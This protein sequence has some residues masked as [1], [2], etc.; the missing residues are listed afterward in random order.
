MQRSRHQFRVFS[1]IVVVLAMHLCFSHRAARAQS[2]SP[3]QP[4]ITQ[5]SGGSGASVDPFSGGFSFGL[6]VVSVPGPEGSGTSMTLSYHSGASPEAG[7]S[8]VG[9]GW[10][11]NAGAIVRNTRGIPDDW[12]GTITYHNRRPDFVTLMVKARLGLETSSD[13]KDSVKVGFSLG[14]SLNLSYNRNTGYFKSTTLDAQVMGMASLS[15]DLSDTGITFHPHLSPAA[16][17]KLLS[18]GGGAGLVEEIGGQLLAGQMNQWSGRIFNALPKQSI[19]AKFCGESSSYQLALLVALP[20]LPFGLGPEVGLD[21]SVVRIKTD[22]VE[23]VKAY[24]YLY[25]SKATAPDQQDYYREQENVPYTRGGKTLPIPLTGADQF[26]ISGGG[27]G[28][29]RFYLSGIGQY[30][31]KAVQ[32]E[33][34]ALDVGGNLMV[35]GRYGVGARVGGRLSKFEV[36][37]W[38]YNSAEWLLTLGSHGIPALGS[39]A[40]VNSFTFASGVEGANAVARFAGDVGGRVSYATSREPEAADADNGPVP[41]NGVQPVLNGGAPSGRSTYIG[42]R[43]NAELAAQTDQGVPFRA[44][45]REW[46]LYKGTS[47]LNRFQPELLN[48]Q[49]GEFVVIGEDGT[50]YVYGLPV[51]QRNY[52]EMTYGLPNISFDSAGRIR[53][54]QQAF[55][56]RSVNDNGEAVGRELKDPTAIAWLL[57]EVY[58][59]GYID[60][61]SDGP[62]PDDHGGYTLYHY[63]RTASGADKRGAAPWYT[64]RIPYNGLA[65]DRRTPFDPEDDIGMA[66]AAEREVY[67]LESIETKSHIAYFLTNKVTCNRGGGF[68][69]I[70]GPLVERKDGYPSLP[71]ADPVSEATMAGDSTASGV[72]WLYP[73]TPSAVLP[74]NPSRFLDR[75]EL[76]AKNFYS[77][78]AEKLLGVTHFEYDYSLRPGLRSS[79]PATDEA[80]D[81]NRVGMLTLRR[82][83]F[84]NQDIVPAKISPWEFGYQYPDSAH[85]PQ[86]MRSLYPEVVHFAD[87]FTALAQNPRWNPFQIDAWGNYRAK[88]EARSRQERPWIDQAPDTAF[89]PAAWQLK[90]IRT[91]SQGE[92]L[93]QYEQNRYGWVQDRR[94]TAMVSLLPDFHGTSS[95]DGDENFYYLNLADAGVPD[96]SRTGMFRWY[97]MLDQFYRDKSNKDGRIYF[98]MLYALNGNAASFENPEYT[99]DNVNGYGFVRDLKIDSTEISGVWHYGIRLRIGAQTDGHAKDVP[100]TVCRRYTSGRRRGLDRDHLIPTDISGP[101]MLWRLLTELGH[102]GFDEVQHCLAI[103]YPHSYVRLPLLDAKRGS[104]VRVRRL[105][106]LDRGPDNDTTLYGQEY[107]YEAHDPGR[108]EIRTSGVATN[109]PEQTREENP[110][111]AIDNR[112]LDVDL[113][114]RMVAGD[115]MRAAEGPIGR[116]LLPAA[117]VGYGRVVTRSIYSGKTTPG[118]SIQEFYT[119][120]DAPFDRQIGGIGRTVDRTPVDRH[121]FNTVPG[122]AGKGDIGVGVVVDASFTQDHVVATQGSRFIIQDMHGAPRRS[123]AYGGLYGNPESWLLTGETRT[124]YFGAGEGI[125][126]VRRLG[127]SI[128]NVSL[129]EEVDV[130]METRRQSD[131]MVSAAVEGDASFTFLALWT[132]SFTDATVKAVLGYDFRTLSTHTTSKVIRYPLIPRRTTSFADGMSTVSENVAFDAATGVPVITRTYDGYHGLE[133]EHSSTGHVGTYHSFSIPAGWEYPAMSQKALNERLVLKSVSG[134][135]QITKTVAGPVYSLSFGGSDAAAVTAGLGRLAE[136]DLVRLTNGSTDHGMYHIDTIIGTTVQLVPVAP[137]L[138]SSNTST[139]VVVNLEV[140]RSGRTNAPSASIGSFTTYGTPAADVQA[141]NYVATVLSPEEWER[142]G[143]F[144]GLLNDALAQGGGLIAAFPDDL[145]LAVGDACV[146]PTDMIRVQ[147]LGGSIKVMRGT[148][149]VVTTPSGSPSVPHPMVDHLNAMVDHLWGWE[150]SPTQRGIDS[151]MN[152]GFLL[153]GG[154]KTRILPATPGSW[155]DQRN[156]R[157]NATFTN[158]NGIAAAQPLRAF[159]VP[160]RSDAMIEAMKVGSDPEYLYGRMQMVGVG[161]PDTV[162][163][164]VHAIATEVLLVDS[165]RAFLKQVIVA[166]GATRHLDTMTLGPLYESDIEHLRPAT[167]N[168]CEFKQD[169]DGYL[170]IRDVY[171]NLTYQVFGV[172]FCTSDTTNLS[173]SATDDIPADGG[174]RF[175][176]DPYG[177]IVFVP[178]EPALSPTLLAGT[179]FCT[180]DTAH[181]YTPGVIAASASTLAD[182]H[183]IESTI[184]TPV[185]SGNDFEQARKNMWLPVEGFVY[186]TDITGGA[187]QASTDHERNYLQAGVFRNF[188]LFDWKHPERNGVEW[189]KGDTVTLYSPQGM[190]LETMSRLGVPSAVRVGYGRTLPTIAAA[191]AHYRAVDFNSFEPGERYVNI[192]GAPDERAHAGTMSYEWTGPGESDAL[193]NTV[194]TQQALDQGVLVRFWG[195]PEDDEMIENGEVTV[196]LKIDGSTNVTRLLTVQRRIARTGE[197][198]LFE[199][200]FD[201]LFADLDETLDVRLILANDSKKFWVD[202]IVM[203]PSMAMTTCMVYE[204][205]TRRVVATFDNTHFGVYPQYNAEGR[206]VRTIVETA[207]G[208]RTVAEAHANMPTVDRV[209]AMEGQIRRR[210][211]SSTTPTLP[212]AAPVS[213][214]MLGE[215]E[216]LEY[217]SPNFSLADVQITP[218]RMGVRFPLFENAGEML[219][220][221]IAD[222]TKQLHGIGDIRLLEQLGQLYARADSLG[223]AAEALSEDAGDSAQAVAR[224]AIERERQTLLAQGAR[225]VK[226]LKMSEEDVRRLIDAIR[227]A[228]EAV[229]A[230]QQSDAAESKADSPS[231]EEA[232]P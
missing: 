215:G 60:L 32:S 66:T 24:G 135:L 58:A 198:S 201:P 210:S 69:T 174:G 125:P 72:S 202:D 144:V 23:N 134:G 195:R 187:R 52:R 225:L 155:I 127:D 90:T 109:E 207:R 71:V 206:P 211:S 118:F 22:P 27:G 149:S 216:K 15:L 62:T 208:M 175:V 56:W 173:V 123:A 114:S 229:E 28:S 168:I 218:D 189:M 138:A 171:N 197:W 199:V 73:S 217:Q 186:R 145:T 172:R 64:W 230:R 140:V 209:P 111:T 180:S 19:D 182:E 143:D 183:P 83:W 231:G 152:H 4:E 126:V 2:Q 50:R 88:G 41:P 110:L 117:S 12:T 221:E 86:E 74:G 6:P 179:Q 130:A 29:F 1:T 87:D 113:W 105:L 101:A 129:G 166:N 82:I 94:A 232:R 156:D 55:A 48:D 132:P 59:P 106:T 148:F 108:G 81:T 98:R 193:V 139:S 115:A 178:A 3:V 76:Y 104:G 136:G 34:T 157:Y 146:E 196:Q 102:A 163:L 190:P 17:T 20:F 85:F 137:T 119:A 227:S 35:G 121:E 5:P 147:R 200:L 37:P 7:A 40:R 151:F 205:V 46:L 61:T 181:L 8:W 177:R 170:L 162:T 116:T 11:L 42:F 107:L 13:E 103:D 36:G 161:A 63:N 226:R 165:V 80:H 25:T 78:H 68:G 93:V 124:D 53:S 228:K 185:A 224:Q 223:R 57:T 194:V 159:I 47:Y 184:W 160:G 203:A 204:P 167:T 43:T 31:P 131:V 222:L 188:R 21:G 49:I 142:R 150:T 45:G 141:G 10:T 79:A 192:L 212:A 38:E 9:Y 128:H 97:G 220:P 26:S 169:G 30:R 77:G 112:L 214:L 213:D 191:N 154:W 84:Q 89:D 70:W 39:G 164:D 219:D 99:T 96:T 95:S 54:R 91:P 176:L 133:L 33:V 153:G 158:V 92:M 44:W 18:H 67:Y 75:I 100:L 51:Y 14:A 65:Y 122:L 120:K 16:A